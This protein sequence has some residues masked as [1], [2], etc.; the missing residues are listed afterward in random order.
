MPDDYRP[1]N[2][3]SGMR[4]DFW[5]YM[6]LRSPDDR[7]LVQIFIDLDTGLIESVHVA[8][9]EETWHSWGPPIKLKKDEA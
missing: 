6:S 5:G 1:V 9:R 4:P 8:H 2:N 3:R 7:V